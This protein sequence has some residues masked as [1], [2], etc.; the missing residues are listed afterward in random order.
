MAAEEA[1]NREK[2]ACH[3][4][5]GTA[6]ASSGSLGASEAPS[7]RAAACAASHSASMRAT[8]TPCH[9]DKQDKLRKQNPNTYGYSE[10]PLPYPK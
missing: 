1:G 9:R 7:A 6:R 5:T 4:R 8:E 3:E 2:E 10:Y